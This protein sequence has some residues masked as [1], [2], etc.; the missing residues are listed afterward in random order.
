MGNKVEATQ[1]SHPNAARRAGKGAKDRWLPQH[2]G[3][4]NFSIGGLVT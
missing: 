4:D 3:V 2:Y 1:T